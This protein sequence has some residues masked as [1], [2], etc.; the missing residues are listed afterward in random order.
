MKPNNYN[1]Y[2]IEEFLCK[3]F[4]QCRIENCGKQ[5]IE[6][7]WQLTGFFKNLI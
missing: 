1:Y 3:L 4:E 6:Y 5:N 7:V 2:F